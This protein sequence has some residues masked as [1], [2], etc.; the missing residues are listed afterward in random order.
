VSKDKFTNCF[1]T[2]DS[3][4]CSEVSHWAPRNCIWAFRDRSFTVHF[5]NTYAV[6]GP[7]HGR[8]S[9]WNLHGVEISRISQ[10]R[11]S[12]CFRFHHTLKISSHEI[13]FIFTFI[14]FLLFIHI[15]WIRKTE[16]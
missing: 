8:R 3:C 1:A 5:W 13:N 16:F 7:M 6:Q 10:V 4:K 14:V 15:T 9:M 2:I 12:S 11:L